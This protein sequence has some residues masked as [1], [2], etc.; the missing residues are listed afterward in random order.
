M[1]ANRVPRMPRNPWR[2]PITTEAQLAAASAFWIAS[3]ISLMA[4]VSH[5]G[6]S[7]DW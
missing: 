4:V 5:S 7:I 1:N 6:R 3:T 2:K